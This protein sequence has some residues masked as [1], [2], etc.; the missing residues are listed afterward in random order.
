MTGSKETFLTQAV[1]PEVVGP[2]RIHEIEG[3]IHENESA[4]EKVSGIR[5]AKAGE[6]AALK[7]QT[8]GDITAQ[9]ALG[10]RRLLTKI[11]LGDAT[12]ADLKKFDRD[13]AEKQKSIAKQ[14]V[15]KEEI[16]T[17]EETVKGLD[18]EIARLESQGK[19]L[20]AEE[21]RLWGV[22]LRELAE[23]A[24]A[25]YR[26]HAEKAFGSLTRVLNLGGILNR[27]EQRPNGIG[28]GAREFSIP[29]LGTESTKL[30]P[31][32]FSTVGVD[33]NLFSINSDSNLHK[34]V[35]SREYEIFEE[36]ER[37]GLKWPGPSPP[38]T[39]PLE[40]VEPAMK[41]VKVPGIGEGVP[42]PIVREEDDKFRQ[43]Q[44]VT[45]E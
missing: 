24:G 8:P 7:T 31:E 19:A 11:A 12:D 44:A 40:L 28:V 43:V 39:M 20:A 37:A 10:R 38:P 32:K 17:L 21:H 26:A 16:A 18:E 45:E 1:A 23:S 30:P 13:A 29:T 27:L 6:I 34:H 33:T 5:D 41:K 36:F 35:N 14:S 22:Y 15:P 9:I 4:R 2:E 25:E 3:R 42:I